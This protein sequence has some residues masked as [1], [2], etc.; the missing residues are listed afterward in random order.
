MGIMRWITWWNHGMDFYSCARLA[1][2]LLEPHLRWLDTIMIRYP[3]YFFLF[4]G[5][6]EGGLD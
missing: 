3:F 6:G 2:L 1:P 5:G 4:G